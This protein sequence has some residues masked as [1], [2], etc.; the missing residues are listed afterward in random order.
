MRNAPPEGCGTGTSYNG[1]RNSCKEKYFSDSGLDKPIRRPRPAGHPPTD[2]GTVSASPVST[3][4]SAVRF[5]LQR[6]PCGVKFAHGIEPSG[7]LE[8][9]EY[10]AQQRSAL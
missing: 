3:N 6:G 5:G 4:K 2:C 10:H 8:P 7:A 1:K 9:V